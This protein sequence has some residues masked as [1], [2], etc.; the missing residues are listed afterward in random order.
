VTAEEGG[1]DEPDAKLRPERS[2][3][4]STQVSAAA[5]VPATSCTDT[6]AEGPAKDGEAPQPSSDTS[7][8]CDDAAAASQ[9]GVRTGSDGCAIG[10]AGVNDAQ[11]SHTTN[12]ADEKESV[13]SQQSRASSVHTMAGKLAQ[14]MGLLLG[15]I[16]AG[17]GH[18][19]GNTARG[20]DGPPSAHD[21][22]ESVHSQRSQASSV[23]NVASRLA[24]GVGLLRGTV[25]E[26]VAKVS[27]IMA[28]GVDHVR[29][30]GGRIQAPQVS[31]IRR[32]LSVGSMSTFYEDENTTSDSCEGAD[33][34]LKLSWE[35]A[36]AKIGVTD[37]A[38]GMSSMSG[39]KV[40]RQSFG[41]KPKQFH[42][43]EA[44]FAVH[45]VGFACH[46]GLK[47]E[48]PNQDDV[49]VLRVPGNFSIFCVTDGH[50]QHGHTISNFVKE[51]L[52]KSCVI[53]P[54]FGTNEMEGMFRDNFEKV[55]RML[56]T[57]KSVRH[58]G[59]M[60]GT[61]CTVVVHDFHAH[62]ITTAHV[63]DSTAVLGK[64]VCNGQCKEVVAITR[65]HKPDLPDERKRIER[66]GGRVIFDGYANHRVYAKNGRYPGLNMSRT[67]G[68]ILGH[69]DAG[70]TWEPDVAERSLGEGSAVIVLCSDGVWEFMTPEEA[71]ELVLAHPTEKVQHAVDSLCKS[72]WDRW[73]AEEGGAVVDDI[74]AVVVHIDAAPR[75]VVTLQAPQEDGTVR[76]SNA[77]GEV[78]ATLSA[79]DVESAS[80]GDL[81]DKLAPAVGLRNDLAQRVVVVS[82]DGSTVG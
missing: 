27:K 48:T 4:A 44:D 19:T 40:D 30:K 59:A 8:T 60:S 78:V 3:A 25:V 34:L 7:A 68:D 76:C 20:A 2:D 11:S 82:H 45:G 50:G 16:A 51:T 71:M 6:I 75:I 55:Q 49:L 14:G 21:E 69:T 62:T 9:A 67:L 74:T 24:G 28:D 66:R 12:G 1:M 5:D 56:Q 65:D 42:G 47:P 38:M 35:E 57:L 15:S 52:V 61:T 32:R 64:T 17:I 22:E 54:R 23:H 39:A 79:A 72:A 43:E 36:L 53:D 80:V 31:G 41:N 10:D 46:K 77:A 70:L 63:G 73:I 29:G 37:F 33:E 13:H 26:G 81:Q 18:S 58:Q